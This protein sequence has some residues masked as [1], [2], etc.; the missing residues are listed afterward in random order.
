MHGEM[1]KETGKYMEGTYPSGQERA[2]EFSSTDAELLNSGMG[3]PGSFDVVTKFK[4]LYGETADFYAANY[5][6]L[7]YILRDL[8]ERVTAKGGN[9]LEGSPLEAAISE[10][11]KPEEHLRGSHRVQQR[12]HLHEAGGSFRHKRRQ[13][14]HR[15]EIPVTQTGHRERGING[16]PV[17]A[18][19]GAGNH[20][21][22]LAEPHAE[23]GHHLHRADRF[24]QSDP[25]LRGDGLPWP[26]RRFFAS[27]GTYPPLSP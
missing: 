27:A 11:P 9:P 20:H 4:E 16:G 7:T 21:G 26:M 17:L 3:Y 13:A 5:Y 18:A 22:E 6:E 23:S 12:W 19:L 24:A 25:G 10:N 14:P 8:I 2:H 1:E 15:E